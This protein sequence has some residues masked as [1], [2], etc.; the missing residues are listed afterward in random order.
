MQIDDDNGRLK[1]IFDRLQGAVPYEKIRLVCAFE[2]RSR[3]AST[4]EIT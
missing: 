3:S 4:E 2:G 1:P